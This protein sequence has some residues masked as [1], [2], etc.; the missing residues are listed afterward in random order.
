MPSTVSGSVYFSLEK[1]GKPG[2]FRRSNSNALE[3]SE[4]EFC[5]YKKNLSD[6]ALWKGSKPNEP[7]WE[8]PWGRGRPGWHIECSTIAR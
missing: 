2:K 4:N 3:I 7:F 6:F 1:F 5:N 8:A